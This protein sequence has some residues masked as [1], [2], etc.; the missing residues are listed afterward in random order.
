MVWTIWIP[1]RYSNPRIWKNENSL[2]QATNGLGPLKHTLKLG[3]GT[4]QRPKPEKEINY[5][6]I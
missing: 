1:N 6:K 3:S 5:V 2:Q 4:S